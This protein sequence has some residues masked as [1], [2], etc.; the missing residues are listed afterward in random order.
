MT[1]STFATWASK[2]AGQSIRGEEVP[3]AVMKILAGADVIAKAAAWIDE[4]IGRVHPGAATFEPALLRS[5][6][7]HDFTSQAF[8]GE[9]TRDIAGVIGYVY[10]TSGAARPRFGDRA[11]EFEAE[12]TSALLEL[13][14]S[15]VFKE[16]IET[17]V[18]IARKA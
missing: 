11:A 3:K 4:A 8:A 5:P 15:G 7:F 6:T 2:T 10:S 17:E 14:P 9:L 16:R 1:W 12:L 13:N 18:I